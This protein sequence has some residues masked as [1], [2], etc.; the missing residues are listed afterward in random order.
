MWVLSDLVAQAHKDVQEREKVVSFADMKARAAQ[1]PDAMDVISFLQQAGTGATSIIGEIKRHSP[2][3]GHLADIP[4]VAALAQIY[5]ANGASMVSVVADERNFGAH[6][7]DVEDV[8]CAVNIPVLMKRLVISP[9]QVHEARARGADAVLLIAAALEQPALISLLDR[10][11]SIGMTAL[12]GT[13]SRLEALR[14]LD[15]G[16]QLIG[17]N[18][19]NYQT[20]EVDRNI[21]DQVIDVIP[22]NVVAV[23]EAT[24]AGPHDIAEFA[25]WGAD[26]VIVGEAL[27]TAT[28]PGQVMHNMVC[29]GS[30]PSLHANRNERV[31][32]A[33]Y[34]G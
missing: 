21:V 28:E 3:R 33:R 32:R 25:Q 16:A 26:A 4:D 18:A 15:A 5:E 7:T 1:V 27:V 9:Y 23:A 30:H 13:N 19:R 24:V 22:S 17:V 8:V 34:L 11:H 20:L 2:Q 10:I 31:R 14:A 6:P 12:V 29:A